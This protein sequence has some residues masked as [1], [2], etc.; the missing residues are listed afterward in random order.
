MAK[1]LKR[2]SEKYYYSFVDSDTGDEWF[3]IG[4]AV[5]TRYEEYVDF[6]VRKNDENSENLYAQR[7]DDMPGSEI[8]V[9]IAQS[10]LNAYE[11]IEKIRKLYEQKYKECNEK[12]RQIDELMER[13]EESKN[14]N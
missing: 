9:W 14:E 3:V 7:I 6:V 5:K 4:I 2:I 1:Q 12:Q 13:L 8:E 11:K 10:I